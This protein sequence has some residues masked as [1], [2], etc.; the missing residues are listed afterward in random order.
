MSQAE[1]AFDFIQYAE[2]SILN[3]N[4]YGWKPACEACSGRGSRESEDQRAHN[5]VT[6]PRLAVAQPETIDKHIVPFQTDGFAET[7]RYNIAGCDHQ[8]VTATIDL[9]GPSLIEQLQGL[10]REISLEYV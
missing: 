4:S 9:S 7:G 1:L 2:V 6:R 10:C 8:L 3:V 5:E